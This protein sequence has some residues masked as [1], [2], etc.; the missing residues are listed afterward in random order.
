[1][2][3]RSLSLA[4]GALFAVS[5]FLPAF[6]GSRGVQCLLFCWDLLRRAPGDELLGWLYYSA[7]VPTNLLVAPII[8]LTLMS[9]DRFVR[10]RFFVATALFFHVLSWLLL[11]W[12]KETS[13]ARMELQVGY[14]VWLLAYALLVLAQFLAVRKPLPPAVPPSA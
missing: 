9:G 3:P 2:N 14:F 10:T 11:N 5:Y 4:A 1:M 7:F 8:V 12:L 13:V 6:A